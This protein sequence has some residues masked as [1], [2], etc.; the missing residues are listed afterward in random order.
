LTSLVFFP[1]LLDKLAS[2]NHEVAQAE[3]HLK[4]VII[5]S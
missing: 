4:L 3:K 1:F 2:C 5:L